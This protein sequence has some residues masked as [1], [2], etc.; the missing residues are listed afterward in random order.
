MLKQLTQPEIKEFNELFGHLPIEQRE[1]YDKLMEDLKRKYNHDDE[2]YK[3]I[4]LYYQNKYKY[5][6]EPKEPKEPKE[7]KESQKGG[8]KKSKYNRTRK[9]KRRTRRFSKNMKNR[10]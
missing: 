2:R 9:N 3:I 4:S 7:S 10:P 6:K 5:N 1:R 8:Y